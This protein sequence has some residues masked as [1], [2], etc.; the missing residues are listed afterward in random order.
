MIPI[1]FNL[2]PSQTEN[3]IFFGYACRHVTLVLSTTY[4]L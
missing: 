1:M 4:V 2:A 3:V